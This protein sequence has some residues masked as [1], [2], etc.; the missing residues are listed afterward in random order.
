[1]RSEHDNCNVID[2][3]RGAAQDRRASLEHG[4]VLGVGIGLLV[5]AVG[6]AIAWL[7]IALGVLSHGWGMYER[8]RLDLQAGAALPWWA[9]L[10][11][12]LCWIGLAALA[13]YFAAQFIRW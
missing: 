9:R 7:A 5:P 1:L 10:L 13:V 8:H 6:I 11:Y 2:G 12:W 4:L 3:C